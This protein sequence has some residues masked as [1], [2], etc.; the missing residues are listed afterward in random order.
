MTSLETLRAAV[1]ASL[2]G[3]PVAAANVEITSVV[4]SLPDVLPGS[5][6]CCVK[7]SRFDGHDLAREA[8]ESGASAVVVERELTNIDAPQLLVANVRD[9]LGPIASC[10]Y[11]NPAGKLKMFGVTGTNGKTTVAQI[12]G[13]LLSQSGERVGV[14]GTLNGA[15][16]SPPATKLQE[17][18]DALVRQGSTACVMEV[19]S[20]AL[21]QSRV[22][23]VHFRVGVFTNLTQD[24]LDYHHTMEDYFAAKARL[25]SADYVDAA[26]VNTDSEWG[27]RLVDIAKNQGVDKVLTYSL[28]DISDL[29]CLASSTRGQWR[30]EELNSPLVGE[31]NASNALAAML[32]ACEFGMT[33]SEVVR[34]LSTMP[35][36][37]GRLERIDVG[38]RFSV[39]VDFAHTPDGLKQILRTLSSVKSENAR[40]IVVFGCGGNRDAAKRPLM[41]SVVEDCADVVIITSDNP[42][43]EDPEAIASEMVAGLNAPHAATVETDRAKA[44]EAALKMARHDDVV[45]I[46][47]KGHETTQE[48]AGIKH[49]FDDREVVR[50]ILHALERNDVPQDDAPKNDSLTNEVGK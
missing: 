27:R 46:A 7:G 40:L 17:Q 3:A 10:F 34:A 11:D 49:P 9:E 8:I 19:S 24:H 6:F 38:Q 2:V 15:Y 39:F 50:N 45:V 41:A 28:N 4:E 25:F 43:D 36:V 5:L 44:I 23:G 33:E 12:L 13:H 42:R 14:I 47:G 16:T 26:V 35:G 37:P 29:Q 48:I 30:G 1:G 32:S 18:L 31:F 21:A 22:K 20:H